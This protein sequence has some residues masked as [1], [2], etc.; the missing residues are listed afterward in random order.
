MDSLSH[1]GRQGPDKVMEVRNGLHTD[2]GLPEH[3][4]SP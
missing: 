1:V 2:K 3:K 4:T